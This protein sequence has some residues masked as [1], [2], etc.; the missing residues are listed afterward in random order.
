MTDTSTLK[1]EYWIKN[2]LCKAFN[3]GNA[4]FTRYI[5]RKAGSSHVDA[6]LEYVNGV[7]N[8]PWSPFAQYQYVYLRV[9]KIKQ[10]TEHLQPEEFVIKVGESYYVNQRL[11][12]A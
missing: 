2:W 8:V 10:T 12:A 6:L 11:N 5:A 9:A 3:D 4:R 7:A 1:P